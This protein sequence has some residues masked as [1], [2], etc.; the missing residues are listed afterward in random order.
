MNPDLETSTRATNSS[1][2]GQVSYPAAA[3]LGR[4][5]VVYRDANGQM[6]YPTDKAHLLDLAVTKDGVDAAGDHAA[7]ELIAK[8]ETKT[9]TAADAIA[10][11][12]E[13]YVDFAGAA[14]KVKELADAPAAG[15]YLII[16][17]AR[18]AAGAADEQFSINDAGDYPRVLTVAE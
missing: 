16:G 8:G 13:V 4:F 9:V 18:V 10:E 7:V 6:A 14:G 1:S 11:G 15:D 2:G 12:K 5:R 3:E 17:R